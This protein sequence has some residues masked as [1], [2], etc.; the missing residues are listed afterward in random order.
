MFEE[1]LKMTINYCAIIS[2][3]SEENQKNEP[4]KRRMKV[5]LLKREEQE[6]EEDENPLNS[7]Q[8]LSDTN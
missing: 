5:F 8:C 1:V 2:K 4:K 7:V 3:N 6:K